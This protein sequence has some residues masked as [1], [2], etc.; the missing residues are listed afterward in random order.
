M[1]KSKIGKYLEKL[2]KDNKLT[3]SEAASAI[4]TIYK[5]I[6]DWEKGVMPSNESLLALSR[7]YNVTVDDILECGQQMTSEEFYEKYSLFK[8]YDYSKKSDNKKD[9]YTP[10]QAKLIVVNT[11][12]KELIMLFRKRVLSRSEDLELRF[13]FT[14]MC[15]FSDYYYEEFDDENKDDY[16]CFIEVLNYAKDVS[17]TNQEYYYEVRKYIDIKNHGYH[18]P[19][20]EYGNPDKDEL[21]DQQFKTLEDWEKDFY[22]ALIQNSDSILNPFITPS[23]LKDYEQRYGCEFDKERVVKDLIKYFIT[24]GAVL[25]PWLYSYVRKKKITYNVLDTLEELYLDFIKPIF[26]QF[27]NPYDENDDIEKYAFVKNNEQNR[28]L[29]DY[30]KYSL[31]FLEKRIDAKQ[32]LYLFSLTDEKEIVEFVYSQRERHSTNECVEYRFKKAEIERDLQYY[33]QQR[34]KYFADKELAKKR[35]EQIN[36]LEEKL[37]NGDTTFFEYEYIDIATE[38]NFD[39]WNLMKRWKNQLTYSQFMKKRDSK[40][41]TDLLTNIDNLSLDEIRNRYFA[42]EEVEVKDE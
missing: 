19:F 40:L 8:P 42:K 33:Y 20:P 23:F 21:K 28:F 27:H 37:K 30:E 38:K 11:R 7:L 4:G 39:H 6:L 35:I 12:L 10:Y 18:N 3:R 16:L 9:Y 22:L 13:F 1:N 26:I 14:N 25:N 5:S 31:C 34:E 24:N 2:R 17:K 32:L 36:V 29:D 41:T 15:A